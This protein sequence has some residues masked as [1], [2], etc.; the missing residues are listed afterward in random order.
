MRLREV[1]STV[2]SKARVTVT[3]AAARSSASTCSVSVTT[4]AQA[5]VNPVA[6]SS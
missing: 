4:A 1:A 2:M 5:P 6:S 3:P